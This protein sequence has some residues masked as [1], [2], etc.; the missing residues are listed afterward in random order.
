MRGLVRRHKPIFP[1]FG[2]IFRS[3]ASRRAACRRPSFLPSLD[4]SHAHPRPWRPARPPV[5]GAGNGAPRPLPLYKGMAQ[6]MNMEL[7]RRSM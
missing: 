2:T 6:A 7:N 4:P 5:P 3:E 1:S